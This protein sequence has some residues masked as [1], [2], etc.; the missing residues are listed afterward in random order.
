MLSYQTKTSRS[1][2][3][4]FLTSTTARLF[5]LKFVVSALSI[6]VVFAV[7]PGGRG[8]VMGGVACVLVTMEDRDMMTQKPRE[9]D[10]VTRGPFVEQ[11][12]TELTDSPV[13]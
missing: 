4:W 9:S 2:S 11:K 7:W 13:V 5:L 6:C 3:G 12:H 8:C 10:R 1:K